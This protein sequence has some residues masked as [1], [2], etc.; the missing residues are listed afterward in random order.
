[1]TVKE[2]HSKEIIDRKEITQSH[3]HN[4]DACTNKL[5]ALLNIRLNEEIS[6]E[7]YAQKKSAIIHEKQK[8]EG[9][10]EDTQNKKWGPFFYSFKPYIPRSIITDKT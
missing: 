1:M 5:D 2:E 9:L 6:A 10:I 8:Y 3:R 4:L 7:E